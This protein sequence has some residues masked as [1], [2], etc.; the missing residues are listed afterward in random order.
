MDRLSN[1]NLLVVSTALAMQMNFAYVADKTISPHELATSIPG[2]V[3][4]TIRESSNM[5][6]HM[7]H[8]GVRRYD[9][10]AEVSCL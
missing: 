6:A 2:A 1:R 8:D 10:I 4:A 3:N 7:N 9:I 5:L